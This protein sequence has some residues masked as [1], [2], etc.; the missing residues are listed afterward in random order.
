MRILGKDGSIYK[1]N[2]AIFSFLKNKVGLID[3]ST[4]VNQGK[5]FLRNFL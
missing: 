1:E 4:L 3:G 2:L 5:V